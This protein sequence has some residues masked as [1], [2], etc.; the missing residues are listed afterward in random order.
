[1]PV[2]CKRQSHSIQNDVA[3]RWCLSEIL[4]A[5]L[6]RQD[7]KSKTTGSES[8]ES[9]VTNPNKY[10]VR[11]S[12]YIYMYTHIYYICTYTY[13]ILSPEPYMC[14]YIYIHIY[15]YRARERDLHIQMYIHSY[16]H[17]YSLNHEF[18]SGV[19]DRV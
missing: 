9:Y 15:I 12:I 8:P 14:M 13:D 1:M 6:G 3:Q 7:S 19:K 5:H 18:R 2:R 11:T 10:N 16:T 17:T 4:A